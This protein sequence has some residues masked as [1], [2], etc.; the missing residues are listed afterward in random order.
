MK[1]ILFGALI[2]A[3]SGAAAGVIRYFIQ[4]KK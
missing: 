3:F 2:G 4:K 1:V